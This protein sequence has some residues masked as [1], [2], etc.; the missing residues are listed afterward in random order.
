MCPRQS[1]PSFYCSKPQRLCGILR[2]LDE[3]G[4][5]GLTLRGVDCAIKVFDVSKAIAS[6]LQGVGTYTKAQVPNVKDTLVVEGFLQH[7]VNEAK[8]P[9]N[10]AIYRARCP[11]SDASLT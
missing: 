1:Q 10:I 5:Q 9:G 3:A 2:L 11:M 8:E 7:S 6:Q 4:K